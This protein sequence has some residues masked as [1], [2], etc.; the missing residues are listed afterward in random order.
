MSSPLDELER[1]KAELIEAGK[2]DHP[3]YTKAYAS[4]ERALHAH[5]DWLLAQ[6]REAAENKRDAERYR[7]LRNNMPELPDDVELYR[8]I[9]DSDGM[10]W[11]LELKDGDELD[12][13]LDSALK[14][15]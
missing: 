10:V 11:G 5:A 14:E 13:V 1:L 7:V 12:A 4:F 3:G 2:G 9:K 15:G 8:E 6:A